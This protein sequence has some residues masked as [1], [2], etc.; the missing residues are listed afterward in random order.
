V[1]EFDGLVESCG[2]GPDVAVD[3]PRLSSFEQSVAPFQEVVPS[4]AFKLEVRDRILVHHVFEPALGFERRLMAPMTIEIREVGLEGRSHGRALD[5]SNR[6]ACELRE[7]ALRPPLRLV[8]LDRLPERL[9][10]LPAVA[11]AKAREPGLRPP[12][13]P[14]VRALS[15][16]LPVGFAACRE[17]LTV[18]LSGKVGRS[19]PV[20]S[21]NQIK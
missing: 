1:A 4:D 10:L 18:T 21:A 8:V 6:R 20:G 2:Y 12:P 14:K 9:P 15:E 7:P 16:T 5:A 17:A 13:K 19:N 11:A 3:G